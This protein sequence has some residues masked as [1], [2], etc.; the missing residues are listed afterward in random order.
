[1]GA[2]NRRLQEGHSA[3]P[4]RFPDKYLEAVKFVNSFR[5]YDHS[6][7]SKSILSGKPKGE[8]PPR[9]YGEETPVMLTTETL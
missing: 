2:D 4:V 1:M 5:K 9:L 3:H 8:V 6:T 7:E